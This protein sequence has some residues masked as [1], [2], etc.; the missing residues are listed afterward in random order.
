MAVFPA[1]RY[2]LPLIPA[3]AVLAAL[4]GR[5]LWRWWR[6]R[7]GRALGWASLGLVGAGLLSSL[8]GPFCEERGAFAAELHLGAG[9]YHERHGRLD[10]AQRQYERALRIDPSLFEAHV[11]LGLLLL[12]RGEPDRAL[13]HHRRA[14]AL[15]SDTAAPWVGAALVYLDRRDLPRAIDA[16]RH[17]VR[18]APHT[19]RHHFL[20]GQ[21]LMRSR[22]FRPAL[23]SF[24]AAARLRPQDPKMLN[25]VAWLRAGRE[26]PDLARPKEAITLAR[27]A[28]ALSWR[29]SP[30]YLDTLAVA[31]LSAGNRS[32]AIALFERAQAQATRQ[33]KSALARDIHRRLQQAR[34]APLPRQHQDKAQ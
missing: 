13:A 6:E 32:R 22:Q 2:R 9:I 27:C 15:R 28:Y 20:L 25:A 23:E 33:G 11:N 5:Q 19:A 34:G 8:P 3:V 18:L 31:H 14:L 10:R 26:L 4:G 7:H 24:L 16:M 30:S 21:L 17:A 12:R 1:G 29:R